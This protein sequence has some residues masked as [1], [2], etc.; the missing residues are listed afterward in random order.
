[1]KRFAALLL[2]LLLVLAGSACSLNNKEY[3]VTLAHCIIRERPET[4][5]CLSDSVADIL[6]AC[7]Y[8]DRIIARSEECTQPLLTNLPS[9]GTK[10]SPSLEQLK[11]LQPDLVFADR[12]IP[13]ETY[14]AIQDNGSTILIMVPAKT[15]DNL[16]RLYESIGSVMG[17]Q[18]SG[19]ENGRETARNL[20][21]LLSDQQRALPQRDVVLTA[22]YLYDAVGH[23]AVDTTLTGKLFDYA[24]AVNVC[25]TA[26]NS[27]DA[28]M[29]LRLSDPDFIFCAAGVKEELLED[30]ALRELKALHSGHVYELDSRSVDR[31][32][33]SLLTTLSFMIDKMYLAAPQNSQESRSPEPNSRPEVSRQPEESRPPEISSRPTSRPPSIS[34]QPAES[35]G[36]TET[37]NGYDPIYWPAYSEPT[38]EP[39]SP[40]VYSEPTPSSDPEPPI[41]PVPS[42]PPDESSLPDDTSLPEQSSLPDDTSLPDQSIL[43]DDTSLPDQSSLPDDTSLPDQSSLPD[44]TSQTDQSSLPDDTSQTDQS[45]LPDDNT[46]SEPED[47]HHPNT[48]T[49]LDVSHP[50]NLTSR[51]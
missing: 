25:G 6:I 40:Y 35:S 42:I 49:L 12:D 21:V 47:P 41:S 32:G 22:C 30:P 31:Q 11:A 50:S 1:M 15:T 33:H 23:A 34:S 48:S 9:V 2:T 16:V 37:S 36:D 46:P 13:D 43:P 3:P 20:L 51:S 39:T 44:D 14:H 26:N 38:E 24:N 45:S 18:H 19:R 4:V 8:A 5:V 10:V 27:N 28:L 17:G 7:G 29:K